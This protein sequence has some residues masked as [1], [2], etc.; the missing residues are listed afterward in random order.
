MKSRLVAAFILSLAA[1]VG[2]AEYWVDIPGTYKVEPANECTPPPTGS[3][4]K[5]GY[6]YIE[7]KC[8]PVDHHARDR[9]PSLVESGPTRVGITPPKAHVFGVIPPITVFGAK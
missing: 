8:T 5:G 3:V 2:H 4:W 6:L 1:G 7:H 9:I